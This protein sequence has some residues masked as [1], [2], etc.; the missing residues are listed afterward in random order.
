[1]SGTQHVQ[2]VH[3]NPVHT[4]GA[5][6]SVPQQ[7]HEDSVQEAAVVDIETDPGE[8]E[9]PAVETKVGRKNVAKGPRR[10]SDKET[11][12]IGIMIAK[13]GENESVTEKEISL[14]D[15]PDEIRQSLYAAGSQRNLLQR[16]LATPV[17]DQETR[18]IS[19]LKLTETAASLYGRATTIGPQLSAAP[20]GSGNKVGGR[21]S[22]KYDIPGVKLV[23]LTKENPRAQ[24]TQGYYSWMLYKDGMTYREYMQTKNYEAVVTSSGSTFRGPGRNHFDWDMMKGHIALY[25]ENQPEKLDDGSPNPKFW[26]INNSLKS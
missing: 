4:P 22:T 2:D 1:M 8:A 11:Q 24:G 16:G 20:S 18:Q 3:E 9:Q 19:A 13:I 17:F 25:D 21:V 12:F 6:E 26:V 15:L 14:S 5:Q 10:L 7:E 23:K